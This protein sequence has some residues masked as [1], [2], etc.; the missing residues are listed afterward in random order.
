[1]VRNILI[2]LV[3]G[4]AA[5]VG[6][7]D[8]LQI[9]AFDN[10][11]MQFA[12]AGVV[13]GTHVVLTPGQMYVVLSVIL[14]AAIC[15]MFRKALVRDWRDF[16]RTAFS[17][18]SATPAQEPATPPAAILVPSVL[19][20]A[21]VEVPPVFAERAVPAPA[22][23]PAPRP[24][25]VITIP[26]SPGLLLRGMRACRQWV[27]PASIRA[28]QWV[29]TRSID[30]TLQLAAL[31]RQLSRATWRNAVRAWHY[32]EPHIRAMDARIERR[33]KQNAT[34]AL[35]IREVNHWQRRLHRHMLAWR[36]HSRYPVE[37]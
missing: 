13:P 8:L 1:M 5:I 23:V 28:W 21:P 14:V 19:P 3:F 7:W 4:A 34:A 2:V 12:T 10:A 11:L 22:Q 16:T 25:V 33:V 15:L 36:N 26:G 18:R 20:E 9:Q 35:I 24:A 27:R 29:V 30:D 32:M 17:R 37:K 6:V 31:V